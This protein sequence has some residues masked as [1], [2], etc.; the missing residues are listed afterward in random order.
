MNK[1]WRYKNGK[2]YWKVRLR[3]GLDVG[4]E[5]GCNVPGGYC[6]IA[7]KRTQYRLHRIIYQ[8]CHNVIL[9]KS[10]MVD[11][12]DGNKQNNRIE[13]LRVCT[14]HQN[15]SNRPANINSKTGEKC[16]C[17][18]RHDGKDYYKVNIRRKGVRIQKLFEQTPK[19]M[20]KAIKLRNKMLLKLDGEFA[21][22]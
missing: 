2:L 4:D 17:P 19:G 3:N 18:L 12:I 13:N 9:K 10:E 11:H 1:L 15:M 20:A 14:I 7:Y 21:R 5:A 16:I 8:I 22:F 6:Q